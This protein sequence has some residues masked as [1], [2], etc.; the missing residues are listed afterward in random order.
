MRPARLVKIPLLGLTAESASFDKGVNPA[1][2]A[3]TR[4]GKGRPCETERTIWPRLLQVP[5][6]KFSFA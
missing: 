5:S 6:V 4:M 3:R 1:L 2:F